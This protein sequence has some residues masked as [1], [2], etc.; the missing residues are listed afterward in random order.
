MEVWSQVYDPLGNATLSTLVCAIPVLVLLGG[1]GIF[2]IRAHYAAIAGLVAAVGIAMLLLGMPNKVAGGAAL[3]GALF[4]LTTICWIIVNLIFLYRMTVKSGLF[5]VLQDSIG[6]I[7]NDRRLQLILIAFCFGAFFEGAAGGGTPVAVT[8]AILIGLGFS[9][10]AA[11]GLSLIANTAPVA[12]GG[13]GTPIIVLNSVTQNTDAY[14]L[15]LSAMVGRQLPFFSV[16]VPFWIVLAF[17]G[18]R[19][20]LQ[21]WP[22]VLVS[23]LSF[24]VPQFL[25]SNYHGP[26]L[27]DMVSAMISI[28]TVAL[29]L[30]FYK[31]KH[32]MLDASGR[33][34]TVTYQEAQL[35]REHHGHSRDQVFKAWL[36]WLILTVILGIWGIPWVKNHIL[37][38]P[39]ITYWEWHIPGL[40]KVVQRVPPAVEKAYTEGAV[41]KWGV[42]SATGT[43][44]LLAAVISGVIMHF[45][46]KEMVGMWIE[47]V[48]IMRFS[49][50]TILA[51]LA[52]GYTT[53]YSG[54][55]A[56]LGL[57]FAHS[58]WLYPFFGT[59]IGWIG[60]ALTGTDAASN[61]LFGS[62]QVITANKLGLSPTLM[63]AANSSGGVMGKMIDA[64]SIVVASV[65]TNYIGKEGVILRY[66]F[67]HSLALAALIGVFVML[68]AYVYP[69]TGLVVK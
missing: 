41:W 62:Q 22:A 52:L 31:P 28:V 50:L 63:A 40:D 65:A 16:L 29:F 57:A 49:I 68:Q 32:V 48:G 39:G 9:P 12:Y 55:D 19:G 61:A 4:A 13:M 8:G 23:G 27:V 37:N 59:I 51:M 18:M 3:F 30:R 47:T 42:L 33:R 15:T 56:T 60:T 17:C 58:G 67:W 36:P 5:R 10:L 6:G 2:R 35:E 54:M 7:T 46:A 44:I 11:S 53:R 43:A 21:V 45:R 20:T 64:Q 38:W 14:L 26:W 1:L 24:A 25:I 34:A 69:F 66:V